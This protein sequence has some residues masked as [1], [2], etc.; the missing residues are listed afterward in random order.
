LKNLY[1]NL[2]DGMPISMNPVVSSKKNKFT[3]G[4][5]KR[6]GRFA[7]ALRG[8]WRFS[9][10]ALNAPNTSSSIFFASPNSMRLFSL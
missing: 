4:F 9:P 10:H 3:A 8:G 6:T 1:Q 2:Q 5:L 7:S